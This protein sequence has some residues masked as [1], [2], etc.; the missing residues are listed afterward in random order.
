MPDE[1]VDRELIAGVARGDRDAFATLVA[2]H[3]DAVWRV[4]KTRSTDDARAEDALQETFLGVW[5]GAS[6]YAGTASVRGWIL[7]LARRQAARTYRRRAG[8]PLNH[9]ELSDLG[10][11]AGWGTC[12]PE[13]D[14]ASRED[15]ERL[16]AAL[17]ALDPE[18]REVIVLR[19]LEQLTGPEAARILDMTLPAMKS[20]LHRAR[21]RLLATLREGGLDGIT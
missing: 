5:R 10:A 15:L 19:D 14:A 3:R 20:R 4:V 12:T 1:E 13:A 21:L 9:V 2:R 6:G 17:D 16:R 11:A 7:G 18:D 8:E